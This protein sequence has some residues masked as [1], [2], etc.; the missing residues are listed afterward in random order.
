MTAWTFIIAFVLLWV[1]LLQRDR[2]RIRKFNYTGDPD[3]GILLFV[4]PVRWL[5]V[6]W[7][8]A[9]FC[10]GLRRAGWQ[11][12]AELILWSSHIGA[13]LVFPDL[14]RPDRQQRF[15]EQLA[16]RVDAL[17]RAHPNR[18][19]HLVGYSG[20]TYVVL[21]AIRRANQPVAITEVILLGAAISPRYPLS[22]LA[23]RIARLHSFHSIADLITG[24]GPAI[25]GCCD[26]RWSPAAGTLGFSDPPAF[27]TQHAW[28][29]SDIRLGYLGDHFTITSP[30]FVAKRIAPILQQSNEPK[31]NP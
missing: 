1:F 2:R 11:G 13:L 24:I 15:A 25:F 26:R 4:E 10:K 5:F 8:F 29:L 27:V 19:I 17:A 28:S 31:D 16:A 12:R 6:I 21:E 14:M 30:R 23:D 9:D 18:P 22:T 3:Q 7:G 20:G